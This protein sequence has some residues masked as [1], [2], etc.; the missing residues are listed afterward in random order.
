MLAY[1]DQAP[2]AVSALHFLW[3]VYHEGAG[4][5]FKDWLTRSGGSRAG[6]ISKSFLKLYCVLQVPSASTLLAFEVTSINSGSRCADTSD[7]VL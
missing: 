5:E 3:E 2:H 6:G 1:R 4:E 7:C